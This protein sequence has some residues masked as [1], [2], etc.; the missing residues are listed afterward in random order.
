MI[1]YLIIAEKPSAGKK[2]ASA[3]GGMAGNFD[4]HS[5]KILCSQGHIIEFKEPHE[6]VPVNQIEKFKSWSLENLPWDSSQMNWGRRLNKANKNAGSIIKQFKTAAKEANAI[7]IATDNDPSGEGEL[8]GW[9]IITA[10][11]FERR[12]L[13]AFFED[14]S[15][16]SLQKAFKSLVEIPDQTKDGHYLKADARSKWDFLSMQLTRAS[17][18][19]VRNAGYNVKVIRQGRLKSV[20]VRHIFEQLEAIKHYKRL[21]YYEVKFKDQ[22]GNTFSRK[23]NNDQIGQIRFS[24]KLQGTND[25]QNYQPSS[26]KI[27]DQQKKSQC[28]GKLLDLASLAANLAPAGFSAD[29]VLS[30]Y[31]KM[32]EAEYVSYPRTEDKK[33]TLE[34]FNDLLP[35]IDQIAMLVNV[36]DALLTHRAP[37]K[38]HITKDAAHGANRPGL[39]VPSSLNSLDQFGKSAQSIYVMLAKNYL[40]IL[41]EDY[42]YQSVKASLATYPSF[43]ATINIPIKRNYKAIFAD[44][45]DDTE[46]LPT[47]RIA[48]SAEPFLFEG[49]NSKPTKPTMKW[50]IKFLEKNNVGQGSTRTS[51]LAEITKGENAMLVEKRGAYDLTEIG[52]LTALINKETWI[53]AVD[54]TKTLNTSMENVGQFKMSSKQ[55]IGSADTVIN[56]DLPIIIKNARALGT[57]FGAPNASLAMPKAKEKYSGQ[58]NQQKIEFAKQWGRYT[59][60]EDEAKRLLVGQELV[61]KYPGEKGTRLMSG[62]L[63]KQR[64]KGREFYGFLVT[65]TKN[66][67]LKND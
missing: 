56:H 65:E 63:A 50:L 44:G 49:A 55:L 2:I 53:G 6:M 45:D 47:T 14:E 5:Y 33:V 48:K 15:I 46:T 20:I 59:F 51:T 39:K 17:T 52:K 4:G 54:V 16:K 25:L 21:P 61:I 7:V 60:S 27:I 19:A 41:A 29:E 38:T 58:F 64:Y 10:I 11:G 34:Q 35:I 22:F 66:G 24:D 9:E 62:K 67:A 32:Y 13:R 23:A 36:E 28:P 40:A 42:E 1:D 8:I 57:T 43:L 18:S 26:I 37:R 12:V 30:T 31:Q 3:L